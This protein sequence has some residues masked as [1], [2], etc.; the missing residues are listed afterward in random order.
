M[1]ATR[2][3]LIAVA[4]FV[5]TSVVMTLSAMVVMSPRPSLEQVAAKT[6]RKAAK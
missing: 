1:T 4:A 3:V 5:T 6:A 2:I